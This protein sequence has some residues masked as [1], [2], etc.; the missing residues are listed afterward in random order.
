MTPELARAILERP[1]DPYLLAIVREIYRIWP[2]QSIVDAI[3][4][5]RAENELK[6]SE[7]PAIQGPN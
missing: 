1:V 3:A 7:N 5:Y 4:H 6:S 2:T